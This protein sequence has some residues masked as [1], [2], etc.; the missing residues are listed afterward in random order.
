MRYN[1]DMDKATLKSCLPLVERDPDKALKL[2]CWSM[3]PADVTRVT[4]ILRLCNLNPN[5]KG[6]GPVPEQRAVV[7][8]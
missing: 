5:W 2:L 7:K 4:N 6:R 8:G 1:Y 3:T